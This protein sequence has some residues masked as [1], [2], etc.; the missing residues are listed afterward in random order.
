MVAEA[1]NVNLPFLRQMIF[2]L[3]RTSVGKSVQR[4]GANEASTSMQI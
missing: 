2:E 4:I 3:W 1:C